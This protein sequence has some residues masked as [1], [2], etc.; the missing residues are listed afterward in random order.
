[1]EKEREVKEI[2]TQLQRLQLQQD[3][4]ISRLERLSESGTSEHKG[5]TREFVI[6]DKVKIS[7]PGL[8]QIT[9]GKI[10]KIG[11]TRITVQG[12]NGKKVVRAPKNLILE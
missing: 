5:T 4:L 1:M 8:F 3:S 2:T 7:N 12:S 10:V 9:K 6:G 11:K